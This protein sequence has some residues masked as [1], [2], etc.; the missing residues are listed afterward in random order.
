MHGL[1]FKFKEKISGRFRGGVQ[2]AQA[3]LLFWVK[4]KEESQ[5][6]EKP[7]GQAT[8]NHASP[9]ATEDSLGLEVIII[10]QFLLNLVI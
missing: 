5:K 7:V 6:D 1:K 8:K 10:S 9:P 2:G 4:K 3:P